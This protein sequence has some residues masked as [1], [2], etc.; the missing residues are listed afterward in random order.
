MSR[1][2]HSGHKHGNPHEDASA[3]ASIPPKAEGD[4]KDSAC[5]HEC[6][7]KEKKPAKWWR[8][9][10]IWT[11]IGTVLLAVFGIPSFVFLYLQLQESHRALVVDQRAWV[12]LQSFQGSGELTSDQLRTGQITMLL[13]NTGKTPALKMT[14]AFIR[15]NRKWVD[16][17]PDY[18][19]VLGSVGQTGENIVVASPSQV[20]GIVL[21][22]DATYPFI[23]GAYNVPRK[24]GTFNTE[25]YYVYKITYQDVFGNMRTTKLCLKTKRSPN[26]VVAIELCPENNW[27]D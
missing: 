23:A 5:I 25:I 2:H 3:P 12:G 24:T 6:C 18:D 4:T 14:I 16:P 17:I 15:V 11:A 26:D 13:K 19:S 8:S 10:E 7:Q 21:A 9:P 22:P 20:G 27:M 1:K